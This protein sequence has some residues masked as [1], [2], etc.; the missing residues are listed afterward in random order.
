MIGSNLAIIVIAVLAV[1]LSVL[2]PILDSIEKLEKFISLRWSCIVIILLIMV[3]VIIDFEPLS[4]ETRN[5]ALKGGFIIIGLFVAVRTIEKV[6]YNGWLKGI[7]IKG[8]IKKGD[9]QG[10]IDLSSEKKQEKQEKQTN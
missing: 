2:I 9:L 8:T 4:D 7:N 5:I 3:G 10:S 6:L 1:I